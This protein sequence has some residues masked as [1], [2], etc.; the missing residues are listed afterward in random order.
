MSAHQAT[1][2]FAAVA[3]RIL[4]A[5]KKPLTQEQKSILDKIIRVDQAGELG[6]NYIYAGQHFVFKRKSPALEPVIKHMWDQEILH[7]NTFNDIQVKNRVRPSLFTPLWRA[8][9]FGV[10]L[11]T[12]LISTQAAMACTEAVETVIGG[13]YNSQ[14]RWLLT[15]FPEEIEQASEL[16]FFKHLIKQFRD[17]EL[18]HL[19][20]AIQHDAH[21]AVP[22]IFLTETI[23][24][25][26][27]AAIW[28]AERF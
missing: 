11:S 26:C 14:L 17:D 6:A 3:K 22:Y 12:A 16:G 23:K 4:A 5:P 1:A 10:G 18:E 2:A 13:H 19:D 9:A 20:T 21:K 15:N 24:A 8:A 28:T 7:H 25:G 27:R